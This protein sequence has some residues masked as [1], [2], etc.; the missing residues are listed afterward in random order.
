MSFGASSVFLLDRPQA[1]TGRRVQFLPPQPVDA[2]DLS[3]FPVCVEWGLSWQEYCGLRSQGQMRTWQPFATSGTILPRCLRMAI[4]CRRVFLSQR[5]SGALR[6][7][8]QLL[9]FMRQR[10][11]PIAHAALGLRTNRR[12]HQKFSSVSCSQSMAG[13]FSMPSWLAR[14]NNGGS[15]CSAP[16]DW[17]T[18]SHH[19]IPEKGRTAALT[20]RFP[21]SGQVACP[22][23]PVMRG[24][25]GD[26]T[27]SLNRVS[28]NYPSV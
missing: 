19:S 5:L 2:A 14:I 28:E 1:A 9:S 24:L 23:T 15:N 3:A 18:P 8:S 17:Q 26:R 12:H 21:Q 22:T 27:V 11:H 4:S 20:Q 7:S 16:A 13:T 6:L 25:M 10:A